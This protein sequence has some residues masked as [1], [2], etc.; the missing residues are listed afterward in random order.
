M[1][2][3]PKPKPPMS[4]GAGM[5]AGVDAASLAAILRRLQEL[6]GLSIA[7]SH[8]DL[9]PQDAAPDLPALPLSAREAAVLCGVLS[10]LLH[11][12]QRTTLTTGEAAAI[13]NVSRP[14]LVKLLDGGV[15]PHDRVGRHRRIHEADL[16]AYQKRIDAK[17]L[18]AMDRLAADAQTLKMGY[19]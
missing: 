11:G 8:S 9:M 1:A 6:R 2:R 18:A 16:W 19:D 13:L 7:K 4:T 3:D 5:R 17:R 10:Q 14:Y 15:I 12:R